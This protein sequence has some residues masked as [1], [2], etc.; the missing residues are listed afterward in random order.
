MRYRRENP[1]GGRHLAPANGYAIEYRSRKATEFAKLIEAPRLLF[2]LSL[3]GQGRGNMLNFFKR[4]V[5]DWSSDTKP[6]MGKESVVSWI[7]R[8]KKPAELKIRRAGVTWSLQGHDFNEFKIAIRSQHSPLLSKCLADEIEKI[9]VR[10][11][12]DI[13]ANIGAVALPLMKK[14][15]DLKMVMFG[16]SKCVGSMKESVSECPPRPNV[17]CEK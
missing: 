7:T 6:F 8:P 3:I 2:V 5:W 9:G 11:V 12:W 17:R 14:F 10:V 13:G 16:P 1:L 15:S 4:M